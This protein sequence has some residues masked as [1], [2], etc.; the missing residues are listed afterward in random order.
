MRVPPVVTAIAV[1]TVVVVSVGASRSCTRSADVV[2]DEG[3]RLVKTG[4]HAERARSGA[5]EFPD[6]PDL[7]LAERVAEA[8]GL[9]LG[10][11]LV[12]AETAIRRRALP[13]DTASLASGLTLLPPGL[14]AD[15]SRP[16]V[17]VSRTS[18]IVV[19]YRHEP[20]AIEVV[21]AGRSGA[22]RDGEIVLVCIRGDEPELYIALRSDAS[23]PRPFA[24][25]GELEASGFKRESIRRSTA[26][27]A[28]WLAE[29]RTNGER[30]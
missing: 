8:E 18:E 10:L 9:A 15:E 23:A 17:F 26:S 12:A 3:G 14:A 30:P 5:G 1:A 27:D 4:T 21:S 29:V 22:A 16:G 20:L 24:G 6:T 25:E 11:A 2:V 19:R 28:E 7:R 13:A